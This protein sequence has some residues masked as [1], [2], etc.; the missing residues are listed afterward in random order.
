MKK[1]K[2]QQRLEIKQHLIQLK[3]EEISKLVEI[4]RMYESAKDLDEESVIDLDDLS[5][6]NQN[7]EAAANIIMRI[8]RERNNLSI[9]KTTKPENSTEVEIGNIV[10]TNQV[11][12]VIGLSFKPFDWNGKKFVGISKEAPIYSALADKKEGDAFEFN[13]LKYEILQIL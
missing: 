13:G 6:Q 1:T 3:E 11:N 7:S 2:E 5:H 10:F 4:E 9:F 8:E 12:L